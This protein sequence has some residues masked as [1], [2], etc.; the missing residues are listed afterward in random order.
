M[1]IYRADV[2]PII[3][4]VQPPAG[5]HAET[6]R[7]EVTRDAPDLSE[8]MR[9]A[10]QH[11]TSANAASPGENLTMR[12][13]RLPRPDEASSANAAAPTVNT[14]NKGDGQTAV[15]DP[16]EEDTD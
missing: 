12:W 1:N 10:L 9:T 5:T 2:I 15:T 14:T 11:V 3:T 7:S 6:D 16:A 4:P 13:V 8:M